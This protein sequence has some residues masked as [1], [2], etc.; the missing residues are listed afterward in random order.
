[1]LGSSGI[2]AAELRKQYN[3]NNRAVVLVAIGNIR[4][5][6]GFE[7]L[8]RAMKCIIA[9]YD[10]T[11]LLIA[12]ADITDEGDRLMKLARQLGVSERVIFLGNVENIARLHAAATIFVCPSLY[13]GFSLV[14]L[15][16]MASGLPVIATRCGGPQEF[17]RH[18][19]NGILIPTHNSQAIADAVMS[20]ISN[21]DI[22]RR[23]GREAQLTATNEFSMDQCVNNY[24]RLYAELLKD[25]PPNSKPEFP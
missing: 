3:I 11:W 24:Q 20:L 22:R 10:S 18:E 8:I 15:E 1:L 19:K 25:L 23:L 12:G 5:I 7:Y 9:S 21:P 4:P 13:E 6:K 17:V 14:T 2:P 16:A